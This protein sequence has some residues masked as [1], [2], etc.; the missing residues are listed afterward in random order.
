MAFIVLKIIIKTVSTDP[1]K[2]KCVFSGFFRL[3]PKKNPVDNHELMHGMR[4]GLAKAA[5]RRRR[6][7][8]TA[9]WPSGAVD[10]APAVVGHPGAAATATVLSG[11]SQV[12]P[13][14][15]IA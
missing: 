4:H 6:R 3:I 14:E 10:A 9:P 11:T 13:G 12:R 7:K 15:L 5:C 2:P 1:L 8:A